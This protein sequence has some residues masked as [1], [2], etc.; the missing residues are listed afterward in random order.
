M[1]E[2]AAEFEYRLSTQA[3]G[4]KIVAE[5]QRLEARGWRQEAGSQRLEALRWRPE[6]RGQ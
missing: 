4:F 2:W 1:E 3:V 5:G 6:A